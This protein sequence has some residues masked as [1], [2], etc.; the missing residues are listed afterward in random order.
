MIGKA[1]TALLGVTGILW[2]ADVPQMLGWPLSTPQYLAFALGLS[3]AATFASF[4]LKGSWRLFDLVLAL[5]TFVS[6]VWLAINFN[7]WLLTAGSRGP[8]KVVPAVITLIAVAEAVRRTCGNI[9][10]GLVL[11][12][13]GYG[14]FSYLVPGAFQGLY[15]A[16]DRYALYLFAD[17][18]GIPGFVLEVA[19]NQILGFILFGAALQICGGTD[20]LTNVALGMMGHRR[21]GS[22][23]VAIVG[24]SLM[25]TISG[26][27]VANVMTTGM[28]TIPMMTRAG[29]PRSYAA[30]V[31]AVASNG[32]QIAPPVMG[33]TAFIIAEFLQIPY[34]QVVVA[35][36]LP[37]AVYYIVLFIYVD[38]YAKANGLLGLSRAELPRVGQVLRSGWYMLLPLG[39]LIYLLFWRGFSPGK[40]ALYSMFAVIVSYY[41][42][43]LPSKLTREDVSLVW[44]IL[45]QTGAAMLPLIAV[46]AAAGIIIGTIAISG[47]GVSLT[48]QLARI[49]EVAGLWPLMI[50][51]ALLSI[52]LGLGMPTAG[53]YVVVAVLMAP[54]LIQ[55]GI[56]PIAAHFFIL[57]FGLLSMITPPVAVASYA[58]ASIANSNL[59]ETGVWGLRLAAP[60]YILPF[61][62]AINP[63]LLLQ[64]SIIEAAVGLAILLA[65]GTLSAMAATIRGRMPMIRAGLIVIGIAIGFSAAYADRYMAVPIVA[66]G[67]SIPLILLLRFRPH[68]LSSS[69]TQDRSSPIASDKSRP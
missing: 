30:A 37:A 52:L 57:Y 50:T 44:R 40:S 5:A 7:D 46:S 55:M 36:L 42:S 35:A 34:S 12:F 60:A 32:G 1:L 21:G 66:L 15:I 17:T 39:L 28:A 14:L 59:W 11:V 41:L 68:F 43:R 45:Q 26:S 27:T 25:G 69:L 58:A 48:M 20:V 6:C 65:G 64:G 18:N 13:I 24:S 54:A 3:L 62:F 29:F 38:Q 4:P 2:I 67:V 9:L 49:G 19:A 33:A 16:P 47:V 31:E 23:K 63:S 53:V 10:A 51:I 8:E 22:A 56:E 61:T